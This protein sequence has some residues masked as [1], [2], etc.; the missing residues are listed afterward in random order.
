MVV[1]QAPGN[2]RLPAYLI[3]GKC[4]HPPLTQTG[5]SGGNQLGAPF[6]GSLALIG[7]FFFGHF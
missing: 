3:D 1:N 6:L 2:P 4:S 5:D 7:D